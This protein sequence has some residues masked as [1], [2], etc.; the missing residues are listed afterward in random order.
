M[1]DLE[2]A[3]FGSFHPVRG[4]LFAP[5]G[6]IWFKSRSCATTFYESR[7]IDAAL[8]LLPIRINPPLTPF[9][10]AF[11][12]ETAFRTKSPNP[13]RLPNRSDR[14]LYFTTVY[15]T[16]MPPSS[17][18]VFSSSTRPGR[19]SAQKS[20]RRGTGLIPSFSKFFKM[21]EVSYRLASSFSRALS[22]DWTVFRS[23]TSL[24]IASLFFFL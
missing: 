15:G 13:H 2:K 12:L 9:P 19:R 14:H 24:Y 17:P 3:S 23:S 18:T 4:G 20:F 21:P 5:V 16:T 22:T 11:R 1:S 8:F 6:E 10:R 7:W